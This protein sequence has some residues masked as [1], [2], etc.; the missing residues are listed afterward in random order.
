MSLL[1][2]HNLPFA[3][4]LALMALVALVQGVGLG[5]FELDADAD[6]DADMDAGGADAGLGGGIASLFGLG[7]VPLMIW[8][9]SFLLL[10]AM[11][12][13]GIQAV[14]DGLLGAPLDPWPA[15]ALAGAAALPVTGVFVRPLARI[16]PRD[17]TT[18][19]E[20]D[21][22]VGRRAT[23]TIGRA[24]AGSPAR[25]QVRDHHGHPHH[26]M[27]EPHEAG[28][29]IGEGERVLLVRREQELFYAV[30]LEDRRLA[31]N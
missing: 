12:G 2:D 19:V 29:I 28:G 31:A 5:G 18:A 22:L 6:L 30:P 10:F 17:H 8:L 3:V 16:L 15:A 24:A 1:A 21:S 25:A 11:V 26:V 27:V 20:L 14:A 23:I 13:L 7:R 9:A 4:A